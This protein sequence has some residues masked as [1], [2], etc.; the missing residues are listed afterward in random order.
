MRPSPSPTALG[1]S[2][3]VCAG[4]PW[5][6][7]RLSH[8]GALA[9]VAAQQGL[10][11][12]GT[13]ETSPNPVN[14]ADLTPGIPADRDVAMVRPRV[15]AQVRVLPSGTAASPWEPRE[16]R[17][18]EHPRCLVAGSHDTAALAGADISERTDPSPL[19]DIGRRRCL[20]DSPC[21]PYGDRSHTNLDGELSCLTYA[22][23][24]IREA[25][26]PRG[27]LSWHGQPDVH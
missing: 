25:V 9:T 5:R 18:P 3:A 2:R 20:A 23:W 11:T 12:D 14:Q 16:T 10:H 26:L 22:F 7:G 19:A 1:A 27:H 8:V 21:A 6:R 13:V 17:R 24:Q 15:S 4:R